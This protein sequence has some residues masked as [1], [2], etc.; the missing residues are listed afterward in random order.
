MLFF[1]FCKL[2]SQQNNESINILLQPKWHDKSFFLDSTYTS[3][4]QDKIKISALKFYLSNIKV[5][6]EDNIIPLVDYK[7]VD[8]QDI[9]TLHVFQK[10]ISVKEIKKIV[11]SIGVDSLASVSGALAG[12]L[13]PSKGMY[14]A[15]QS[16]YIN[17]KLEG[18]SPSC[19]TRKQEFQFHIGG[20]QNPYYALQNLSFT[21][22][23]KKEYIVYIDIA[24][25][26]DNLTLNSTNTVL[27][28]GAKAIELAQKSTK[29]FVVE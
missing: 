25:F 8:L 4:T 15:W 3:N 20:Y 23:N 14:W 19:N 29:M 12:D 5:I 10:N 17:L 21:V 22:Q 6:T 1:L 16:G 24:N 18:T 2:W 27:I 7:L 28:P 26:F 13:D 11:F 9:N